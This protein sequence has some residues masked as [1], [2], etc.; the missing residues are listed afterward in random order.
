VI[1]HFQKP[2]KTI[3]QKM[4]LEGQ[5]VIFLTYTKKY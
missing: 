3:A 2:F 1:Q 5:T 4:L